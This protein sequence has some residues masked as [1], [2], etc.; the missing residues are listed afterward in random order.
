[1]AWLGLKNERI[2]CAWLDILFDSKYFLVVTHFGCWRPRSFLMGGVL[3]ICCLAVCGWPPWHIIL[4]IVLFMVRVNH[5]KQPRP[6]FWFPD[7]V[8]DRYILI[9]GNI[10]ICLPSPWMLLELERRSRRVS[11]FLSFEILRLAVWWSNETCIVKIQ[12]IISTLA[13]ARLIVADIE[14]WVQLQLL[15]V[16]LLSTLCSLCYDWLPILSL[17]PFKARLGGIRVAKLSSR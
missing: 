5:L 17:P 8:L 14:H 12:I 3:R 6:I 10:S 7:Y 2:N 4:Q 16:C 15:C 13:I 11:Y 9:H 1:M